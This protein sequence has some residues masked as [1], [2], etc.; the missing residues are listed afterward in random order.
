MIQGNKVYSVSELNNSVRYYLRD[1]APAEGIW[2]KGEILG[3]KLQSDKRYASFTLCE[4]DDESNEIIAK[5][6]VMCWGTELSDIEDKLKKMDHSLSLKEGIC[7]QLK[8]S[9]DLWAQ[10]GRYQIIVKD[11]EPTF[12][13]GELHFLRIKIFN[14]LKALCLHEKN[15]KI[16]I[17][18]YPIRVALITSRGCAGYNDFISEI[19]SSQYPFSI[20][21]Y[22]ASVQGH[23]V[24]E[25]VI[26]AIQLINR[27]PEYYDVIVIVRG[28]GGITDLKWFDNKKIGI[29]IAESKLPV[30]TGIGHEINLTVTDMV[31]NKNFKTPTAVADFLVNKAREFESQVNLFINNIHDEAKDFLSENKINLFNLIKEIDVK[32]KSDLREKS[33]GLSSLSENISSSTSDF[34]SNKKDNLKHLEEKIF[35]LDPKY[36]VK[37]GYSITRNAQGKIIKKLSQVNKKDTIISQLQDGSVFSNVIRKEK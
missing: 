33:L 24:E 29:A 25:E 13:L 10:N 2:V 11:I 30:L 26:R 20:D 16:E 31:S 17:P 21:F 34:L 18:L 5:V 32:T 12:T 8:C 15:K 9:L 19:R 37:L 36:T 35:L 4:K 28:G 1:L 6:Q 7:V 23:M 14:E 3:Y 27:R 22:H